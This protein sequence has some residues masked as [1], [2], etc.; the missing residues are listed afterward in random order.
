MARSTVRPVVLAGLVGLLVAGG[1]QTAG[2]HRTT[3]SVEILSEQATVS[4]DGRSLSFDIETR[5]DRKWTIVEARVGATQPQ[6]SGTGS[7]T[8]ACNRLPTVVGVTVPVTSGVFQTGSANVTATLAVGQ[9]PGKRAQDSA[10]VRARPSVSVI[11]ADRA[12]LQ[13]DGAVRID[14]TVR[15]PMSAVGQGGEVRIYDGHVAGTATFGP[16][17]CDTL[18]HTFSVRVAST[19]GPFAVGSAEAT[20]F[21]SVVEGGDVFPSSDLR[22]IQIVQA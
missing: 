11:L 9:G 14:V 15:C 17:P 22:T 3:L 12:T 7:F 5:C 2:A 19:Q 1:T 6:A 16:T 18:P 10:S 21:A 4:P 20:A 13:G 8:P